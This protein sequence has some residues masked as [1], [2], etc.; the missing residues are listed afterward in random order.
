MKIQRIIT[1]RTAKKIADWLLISLMA[2][3]FPLWLLG[4][5]LSATAWLLTLRPRDAWREL[6]NGWL[7]E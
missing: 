5:V 6:T 1:L 3:F 2:V 7:D 4:R